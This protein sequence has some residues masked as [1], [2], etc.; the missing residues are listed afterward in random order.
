MGEGKVDRAEGVLTWE[1]P[2]R[3]RAVLESRLDLY[4]ALTPYD[5]GG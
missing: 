1:A 4:E 2:E 5:P 3:E